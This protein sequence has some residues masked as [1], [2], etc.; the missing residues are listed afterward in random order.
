MRLHIE[1]RHGAGSPAVESYVRKKAEA[2]S[3]YFDKILKL[4]VV[5]EVEGPVHRVQF[6]GYLLNHKV[7]KALAETNDI[8]ASIDEAVDKMQRQL[9]RFKE[10]LRVARKGGR[11]ES[12]P[13]RTPG[14]PRVRVEEDHSL[15]ALTAE[16]AVRELVETGRDFLVFYHSPDDLPAV[17]YRRED[18]G[19]SLVLPRR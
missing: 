12:S 10:R 18:G 3:R 11:E 8:Y 19:Y 6:T 16:E 1:A 15:K 14:L 4:D 5:L 17:V 2:L 7:V 13:G 9:V